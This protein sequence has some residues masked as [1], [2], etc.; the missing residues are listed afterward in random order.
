[1]VTTASPALIARQYHALRPTQIVSKKK[2]AV[3]D[4]D[5]EELEAELLALEREKR[6]QETLERGETANKSEDGASD[7]EA[8]LA[9]FQELYDTI[10]N[11]TQ[12]AT[13]KHELP[14]HSSLSKLISLISNAEQAEQIPA[15]VTQW[16]NRQLPTEAL[17]SHRLIRALCKVGHPDIALTLL[18]DREKYN[19][20]PNQASM[21][22]IVRSFV[23]KVVPESEEGL[24]ELDGAFLTMAVAPYYNLQADDAYVYASLVK[25]SLAYGGE[26]GLRRATAT[27]D[28][29]LLIDGERDQ[30]LTKKVASELVSAAESLSEAYQAN[31]KAAKAKELDAST[32]VWKKAL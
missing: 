21:R 5:D 26:E 16:R 13:P 8:S 32:A 11:K 29:Y 22:K 4:E 25:G 24:K 28:E 31:D 12:P 14:R 15:L 23:N 10:Y 18:G 30:P 3:L 2:R 1:M 7:D 6:E 17:E 20:H 19:M 27:M 9:Q